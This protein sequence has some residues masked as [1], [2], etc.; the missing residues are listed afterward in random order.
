VYLN[1]LT[2][3]NC[4]A[5]VACKLELMQPCCSVKDRIA[6]SMIQQ[7][8]E[9]GLISPDRT[10]LVRRVCIMCSAG[11][12]ASRARTWRRRR[13]SGAQKHSVHRVLCVA[14]RARARLVAAH[15][16]GGGGA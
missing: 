14:A 12:C 3:Q 6:Y 2:K 15:A 8:E 13:A 1:Q 9:D 5:K 4:Y 10:V 7:A 11:T 16:H